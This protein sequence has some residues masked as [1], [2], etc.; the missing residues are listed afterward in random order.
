MVD[1]FLFLKGILQL[2]AQ[3]ERAIISMRDQHSEEKSI[4][5]G[6]TFRIP[7]SSGAVAAWTRESKK[8]AIN[9]A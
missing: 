9:P 1:R 6:V 4:K 2:P 8:K 5:R 3:N 7:S